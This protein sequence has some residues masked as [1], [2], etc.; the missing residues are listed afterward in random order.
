MNF[1]LT[2]DQARLAALTPVVSLAR[3]GAAAEMLGLMTLLFDTTLAY[4]KTRNQ[5]GQ[6]LA[7]FQVIQHR[8][9]DAYVR[10]EQARSQVVRAAAGANAALDDYRC[11]A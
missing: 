6:A 7:A 1:D 10:V 5:F 8:M 3:F 9:T 11:A 2:E 4:V